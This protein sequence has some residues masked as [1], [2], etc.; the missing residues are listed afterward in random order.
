MRVGSL[1]AEAAPM[2]RPIMP[3]P[4]PPRPIIGI[5]GPPGGIPPGGIPPG[6]I[7]GPPGPAPPSAGSSTPPVS[8]F[9]TFG[10]RL[11]NFRFAMRWLVRASSRALIILIGVFLE[12]N[13]CSRV[14]SLSMSKL[15]GNTI[16]SLRN[17]RICPKPKGSP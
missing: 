15:K 7:P 8:F 10:E 2:P 11:T 6:G 3:P 14:K 12:V 16:L 17:S 13:T 1:T 9:K 4:S 5:P